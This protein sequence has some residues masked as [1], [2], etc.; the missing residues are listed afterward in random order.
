[1]ERGIVKWFDEEKGFGFIESVPGKTDFFVHKSNVEDL[2][3]SLEKG[4]FVE[5]EIGDRD[6]RPQATNVRLLVE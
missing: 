1:M 3:N 5:F 4:Q 2:E 6:G